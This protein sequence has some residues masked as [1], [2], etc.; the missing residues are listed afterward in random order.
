[1]NRV[2]PCDKSPK[3]ELVRNESIGYLCDTNSKPKPI[4]KDVTVGLKD[5]KE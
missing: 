5:S 4:T 1:M 2:R 3:D